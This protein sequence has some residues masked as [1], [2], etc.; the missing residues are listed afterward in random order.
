MV[1]SEQARNW[2]DVDRRAKDAA[3]YI[4]RAGVERRAGASRRAADMRAV[5]HRVLWHTIL[6]ASLFFALGVVYGRGGF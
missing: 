3:G 1:I 4:E 6:V 5:S 2:Q